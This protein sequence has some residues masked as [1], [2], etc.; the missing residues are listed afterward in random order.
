[1][2]REMKKI[3]NFAANMGK[4]SSK[5]RY[6]I[7]MNGKKTID[8]VDPNATPNGFIDWASVSRKVNEGGYGRWDLGRRRRWQSGSHQRQVHSFEVC[9]PSGG[10]LDRARSSGRSRPF[11]PW[12]KLKSLDVGIFAR[13]RH[14]FL[15]LDPLKYL[16]RMNLETILI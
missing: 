2:K 11:V 8:K 16:T 10:F 7:S 12:L 13:V 6:L 3:W 5:T 9:L 14:F 15:F 4:W 1:M